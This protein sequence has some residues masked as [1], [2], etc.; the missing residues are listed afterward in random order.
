[1]GLIGGDFFTDVRTAIDVLTVVAAFAAVAVADQLFFTTVRRVTIAIA[2]PCVALEDLA[3]S[4]T[5]IVIHSA[6]CARDV[7]EV[8]A[9]VAAFTAVCVGMVDAVFVTVAIVYAS[10]AGCIAFVAAIG[11][12]G[13]DIGVAV[14]AVDDIGDGAIGVVAFDTVSVAVFIHAVGAVAAIGD[15]D[16][17]FFIAFVDGIAERILCA[18]AVVFTVHRTEIAVAYLHAEIF[19]GGAAGTGQIVF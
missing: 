18:V 4:F 2:P 7:R 17:V 6:G 12:V 10:G 16:L 9:V 5:G 3:G 19:A 14:I 1:M 8:M 13:I 15:A 11:G